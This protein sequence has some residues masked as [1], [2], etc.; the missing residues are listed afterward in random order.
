MKKISDYITKKVADKLTGMCKTEREDY[1]KYW[2]DINPFIKFGCLKDDKFCEKMMDYD[3]LQEHQKFR[4][5]FLNV[6][7]DKYLVVVQ[8]NGA[9][10]APARDR[11]KINKR[12][13]SLSDT[14]PL[15]TSTGIKEQYLLITSRARYSLANSRLSS[16]KN[17]VISVPTSVRGPGGSESGGKNAEIH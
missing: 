17:R 9:F 3:A 11:V 5:H 10:N 4:D 13:V 1:E 12:P 2:D 6:I 15:W 8:L 16:F 7:C 14:S